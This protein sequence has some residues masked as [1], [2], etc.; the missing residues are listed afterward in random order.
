MDIGKWLKRLSKEERVVV[1]A[2]EGKE[3]YVLQRLAQSGV[4]NC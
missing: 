3:C 2:D 1:L 4:E